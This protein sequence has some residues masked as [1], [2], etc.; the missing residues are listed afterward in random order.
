[1]WLLF[2]L[3][4]AAFAYN[5]GLARTP[6]MGWNSWCTG[7]P[8][9]PSVCNLRGKDPCSEAMVKS[10]ADSIVE[11]GM[12]KLGYKYVCLDDCVSLCACRVKL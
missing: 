4:R 1:M 2:L 12:D 8:L 9:K 5:N 11:Q 3:L 6:P 10:I 7:Q